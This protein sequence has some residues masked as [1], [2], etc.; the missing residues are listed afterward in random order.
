MSE[1]GLRAGPTRLSIFLSGQT[2]PRIVDVSKLEVSVTQKDNT[3]ELKRPALIRALCDQHKVTIEDVLD[4][5]SALMDQT[6]SLY[7]K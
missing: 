5:S 3:A 2:V 6:R 7:P 4:V 1:C